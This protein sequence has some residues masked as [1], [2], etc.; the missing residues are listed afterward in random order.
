MIPNLCCLVVMIDKPPIIRVNCDVKQLC[1]LNVEREIE[2][3]IRL[4]DPHSH[5]H[6]ACC[7]AV[8]VLV[9]CRTAT[10]ILVSLNKKHSLQF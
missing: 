4:A 8:T 5:E 2:A 6:I 1:P 7:I 3:H 10:C 9:L